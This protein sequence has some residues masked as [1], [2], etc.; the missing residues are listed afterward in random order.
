M[1]LNVPANGLY[2]EVPMRTFARTIFFAVI[3]I[4][5]FVAS[6]KADTLFTYV[7]GTFSF[8]Q[9]VYVPGDRITGSFILPDSF[10]PAATNGAQPVSFLSY[11]FTDGHQTL[12]QYNSTAIFGFSFDPNTG[13]LFPPKIFGGSPGDWR[14]EIRTSTSGMSAADITDYGISAWIGGAQ[15]S[16]IIGC[17]ADPR[18]LCYGDPTISTATIWGQTAGAPGLP[19]TWTLQRVP[20]GGTTALFLFAGLAGLAVLTHFKRDYAR[21]LT[22]AS[23]ATRSP[24]AS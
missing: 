12:T 20:E 14:F 5:V 18:T 6:A 22:L 8:V 23:P 15:P 16:V 19:G 11:S 9:G 3:L 1:E 4:G 24:D 17:P 21:A 10:I 2:A 7:G 13:A